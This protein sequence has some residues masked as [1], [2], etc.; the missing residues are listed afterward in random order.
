MYVRA[1]RPTFARPCE[2]V[3]KSTPLMNSPASPAVSWVL[4][5]HISLRLLNVTFSNLKNNE[6]QYL[7]EIFIYVLRFSWVHHTQRKQASNP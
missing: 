2:G 6:I 5:T 3:H 7:L 4:R 1:G